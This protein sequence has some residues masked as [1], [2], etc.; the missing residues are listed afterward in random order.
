M[1]ENE[2]TGRICK[3]LPEVVALRQELHRFPELALQEICTAARIRKALG[4]TALALSPPFLE[5][6]VVG[7]LTG[8]APGP[9]VT[10]RADIDALPLDELTDLPYR[11]EH[12]GCMHACGH[13]GHT[14]MLVGAARVL[15]ELRDR[16]AG[17]VRFVFQPGE[18]VV[19]AGRDLVEAGCLENPPPDMLL[20]LH[21]RDELPVGTFS[22]RPGAFMA[23][24]E[25]F[26]IRIRGRGAHGSRPEQAIDPILTAARIVE[27]LEALPARQTDPHEPVVVS[28]CRIEGGRNANVIPDSAEIEGTTRYLNPAL[29]EALPA[30]IERTVQGLCAAAGAQYDMDY[31]PSYAP[32]VNDAETVSLGERVARR[33]LGPGAWKTAPRPSLGAEDFAFYLQRYPGALFWIGMGTDAVP[34]HNPRFD[35]NDKALAAGIRFLVATALERLNKPGGRA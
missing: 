23:A 13:D 26:K 28:V 10:L 7:L 34:L 9:N 19:A 21:A 17:S 27:A 22:S 3:V 18:E 6:D 15:S 25:M 32:T 4:E 20:A 8:V 33:E 14:A 1:T 2:L 31:R 12:A 24:A 35:F 30:L 11:S 5:T 29:G 16:F